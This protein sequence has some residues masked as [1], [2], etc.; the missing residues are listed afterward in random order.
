MKLPNFDYHAPR[1][2]AE[3]VGLLSQHPGEA[4]II[5]GGQSLLPTMAY[6]M[7]QPAVLVDLKNVQGLNHI[8]VGATRV[9]IG[10]RTRWRDIEDSEALDSAHP[11]LKEA[12]SHI[13]HYQVRNRGTI[14]GSLAHADPASELPCVAVTCDAELRVL[15]SG[16]ERTLP[17]GSFFTGPLSTVLADDEMILELWL[18]AWPL[19]RRWAFQEFARRAG[20]FAMAGIALHYDVDA[21]GCAVDVHIGVVGACSLPQRLGG[22]EA[23]LTGKPVD[24]KSI[25]AAALAA[26]Q[27]VDPPTDIHATA[28][29]RRALVGTLLQR[30]LQ[31]AID[32]PAVRA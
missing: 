13:A 15:G 1:T 10:A 25:A 9:R 4:K 23:A 32:R 7:A 16:G 2:P 21:Q 3:V 14:G 12:V 17:A 22:A 6:R 24:T 29:Y 18:P 5:A 11:L 20:D 28:A 30:S 8:S 19:A 27:E 31:Q 26:S